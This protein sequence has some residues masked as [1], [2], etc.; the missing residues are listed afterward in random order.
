MVRNTGTDA[1]ALTA[2]TSATPSPSPFTV[3]PANFTLSA[4]ASTTLD[5]V[6]TVPPNAAAGS[7]SG[8]LTLSSG[9]SGA[10]RQTSLSLFG[11][12]VRTWII[13][14]ASLAF[15]SQVVGTAPQTRGLVLSNPSTLPVRVFEVSAGSLGPYTLTGLPVDI[16]AGDSRSVTVS[17]SPTRRGA[18]NVSLQLTSTA[19]EPVPAVALSGQG[20][21]P[22]LTVPAASLNL[23]FGT[24]A[25][26]TT[27]VQQ[28]TLTNG[29][30]ATLSVVDI[31]PLDTANFRVDN[32]NPPRTVAPGGTL[33]FNVAFVP[34][35]QGDKDTL[36][37]F[38]VD[39]S[40][41]PLASPQ[42]HLT[43]RSTGPSVQ[44]TPSARL[45]FG[46]Q[47]ANDTAAVSMKVRVTNDPSATE[48]LQILGVRLQDGTPG[49]SL[50]AS[51]VGQ[52]A[53][54]G[55]SLDVE[56][57]FRPTLVGRSYT[58][59]LAIEFQGLSTQTPRTQRLSVEGLGATSLLK[60]DPS[61]L[62]F[63]AVEINST[64]QLTITLTNEGQ[65]KLQLRS[66]TGL[67]GTYFT[68]GA[69][70]WPKDIPAGGTEQIIVTFLSN[71]EDAVTE[72]LVINSN[73]TSTNV[74]GSGN[75]PVRL[76]GRGAAPRASFRRKSF[77]L[78]EVPIGQ[79]SVVALRVTNVGSAPL[80]FDKPNPSTHFKVLDPTTGNWP[81]TIPA[82]DTGLTNFYDFQLSFQP[83]SETEVTESLTLT[84][85]DAKETGGVSLTGTGTRPHLV[86][87]QSLDFGE[88]DL[89]VE[90]TRV[91]AVSN[92]GKAPLVLSALS[93][94]FPYCFVLPGGTPCVQTTPS[95]FSYSVARQRQ[96]DLEL[97]VTP[98]TEN[99]VPKQL[100]LT[101]NEGAS[102]GPASA[103][104]VVDLKV[105]GAGTLSLK[106]N[107]LQFGYQGVDPTAPGVTQ[108]VLLAN[109]TSA[110]L[111][112]NQVVLRMVDPTSGMTL[113]VPDD[114]SVKSALP[115][116]VGAN[117][118]TSLEF[119]FSPRERPEL[120]RVA[121]AEI[122]TTKNSTT[123]FVLRLEGFAARPS[124]LVTRADAQPFVDRID[125]QQT[126]VDSPSRAL[127]LRLSNN[128]PT[129]QGPLTVSA[130]LKGADAGMFSLSSTGLGTPIAPGRNVE[131][132]VQFTPRDG[133]RHYEATLSLATT[134]PNRRTFEVLLSGQ[135]T[136][137]VLSV[138]T[139]DLNFGTLLAGAQTSTLPLVLTNH[140]SQ[141]FVLT[142]LALA[143]DQ[144]THFSL[145]QAPWTGPTY[146][147]KPGETYTL[148]VLFQPRPDVDSSAELRVSTQDPTLPLVRVQ[149]RGSGRSSVFKGLRRTVDFGTQRLS[150]QKAPE[151][152]SLLNESNKTV[153]VKGSLQGAQAGD[154][155]FAPDAQ[156]CR[157]GALGIELRTGESCPLQVSYSTT[158][159]T[160][161]QATLVLGV[162]TGVSG[163]RDTEARI[164][165]SGEK[166]A[167][168]MGVDP[169]EV[170]FGWVD[171]DETLEPRLITVTNQSS[172]ATRVLLPE[173][174]NPQDFTVEAL[175]PGRELPPAATTQLRVTF[176]PQGGGE[177]TGE[178]RLRL[179][180]E[181][182]ADVTIALKGQVRAIGGEGGAHACG[183]SP[184]GAL[185]SG[186]WLLMLL[187][188]PGRRRR[189]STV[190]R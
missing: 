89:G 60:V 105:K 49:L 175:E 114:F 137:S 108:G 95:G 119:T 61:E 9:A 28:V 67:S 118:S 41:T 74:D 39:G 32:L 34:S 104:Q 59:T 68:L 56:V 122:Y 145:G 154:F 182:A 58:D 71:R 140:S 116:T 87:Q 99:T 26:D 144:S 107:T 92:T 81:V 189:Q 111:K 37:R 109:T 36:L 168:F 188:L 136:S 86:V 33:T 5:V 19:T 146:A 157:Q 40:G 82:D 102:G 65:S 47:R 103:T 57:L 142:A 6:F 185:M 171:I 184:E 131:L 166:V 138:S 80:R 8:Q 7:W 85:N 46:A 93:V 10:S 121:V 42:L 179:Q 22:E 48:T 38:F 23:N 153:Y 167:S 152:V 3:S 159:I 79:T 160:L 123:P 164:A 155:T 11:E 176:H 44:F 132:A 50:G 98:T 135:G 190:S 120:A 128:L 17:F 91:L 162:T 150:E 66:I 53:A 148:P 31:A 64:K 45:N 14:T 169:L 69:L 173:V 139:T 178:L 4:G 55:E 106:A 75:T 177:S 72:N 76:S 90:M 62:S 84:S 100:F 124:L 70:N 186:G 29:G 172:V 180:G 63:G 54:P 110:E 16:P 151:V 187:A 30:D 125:F 51:A 15:S 141:D 20:L 27:T 174:S 97:R 163:D 149:L 25:P 83:D 183:A 73:A 165:L 117:G 101:S 170:D 94:P 13:P 158:R 127:V 35:S 18:A 2:T 115:L 147:I 1:V 96:L 181:Q 77:L 112:V 12:T 78:G 24:R 129:A 133:V 161:S 21:A 134:D 113:Q 143:G 130:S 43:G 156:S 52:R 88:G 126:L